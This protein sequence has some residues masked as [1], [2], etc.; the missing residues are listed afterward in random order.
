MKILCI[1]TCCLLSFS[2]FS[3][4]IYLEC[5]YYHRTYDT[6][7]SIYICII[8]NDLNILSIQSAF[9]NGAFGD[10]SSDKSNDQVLGITET[11]NKIHFFPRGLNNVF[12]RLKMIEF[13]QC[14][15][16]EIHQSDLMHLTRLEYLDLDK[17]NIEVIEDGLFDFN[18]SMRF[19]FFSNNKIF[20][21]HPE[22]F[23]HL[24]KLRYLYMERNQCINM[25]A[26]DSLHGVKDV[27]KQFKLNCPSP[28]NLNSRLSSSK[29]EARLMR[30]SLKIDAFGSDLQSCQNSI[31]GLTREL[32][33]LERSSQALNAENLRK[34]ES[35]EANLRAARA[36]NSQRIQNLDV[37]AS[38]L[39]KTLKSFDVEDLQNK[40]Q[41]LESSFDSLKASEAETTKKLQTLEKALKNTDE[42][43]QSFRQD[44]LSALQ[45]I[46]N[47]L[48][49]NSENIERKAADKIDAMSMSLIATQTQT[50]VDI[51]D[52]IRK[53]ETDLN[54]LQAIYVKTQKE[55]ETTCD[56][57]QDD[58]KI[59]DSIA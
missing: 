3:S 27:I 15:L 14:G 12:K 45:E 41:N 49:E 48:E 28:G 25:N 8:H 56:A 44:V 47:K 7:G 40:T 36:E 53:L 16:L 22:V 10:L 20:E 32:S 11:Y 4:S 42:D 34:L 19:I 55:H 52:Q 23:D 58:G 57:E 43:L 24:T 59:D 1:I 29:D 51:K 6:I 17:N 21:I 31:F 46:R 30:M 54:A 39:E 26:R 50:F 18:P 13:K 2:S 9:I 5:S 35:V 33:S 38:S 37:K